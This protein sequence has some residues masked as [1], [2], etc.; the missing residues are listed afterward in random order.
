[1]EEAACPDRDIVGQ[2]QGLRFQ[3]RQTIRSVSSSTAFY[4]CAGS[5]TFQKSNRL[6]LVTRLALINPLFILHYINTIKQSTNVVCVYMYT[7]N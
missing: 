6:K 5:D 4:F 1:M 2:G 7:V 3:N